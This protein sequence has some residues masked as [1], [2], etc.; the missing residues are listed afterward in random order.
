MLH[1]ALKISVILLCQI[2][3]AAA[4]FDARNLPANE[5][6]LFFLGQNSDAIGEYKKNVY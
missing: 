2:S 4:E 3:F 5:K 6:I 1:I